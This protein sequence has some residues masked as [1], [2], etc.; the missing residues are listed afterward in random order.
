MKA[1]ICQCGSTGTPEE[2]ADK[3]EQM[4]KTAVEEQKDLDLIVF[5]EYCYYS[6][7]D[8]TDALGVAIDL[9]TNELHPFIKR[10]KN[11]AKTCHVNFIPGSFVEKAKGGKVCNTTLVL[12]R[13]GNIIGKYRKVHLFD[14]ANYK[15]SS[16]V[17]AGDELCLVKTDF[18]TIGVMVCYDLRF[19]EQAR[20]MCLKGAELLVVPAEFPCG[21]PLPPRVDDWDLLVRSTALTNLTYVLAANQFGAVHSDHPFGRSAIVDPRGTVVASAQGREGIVY[22]SIDLEYQRQVQENLAVW[23]N[24]RPEVYSL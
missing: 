4:F 16:Y 10:M 6:P 12:N 13:E 14:A 2:N 24:R 22:A 5:P 9:D 17:E 20:S 7:V 21:Q 18:G 19:P 8:K 15:E 23:V 3:M 1:A 11:L